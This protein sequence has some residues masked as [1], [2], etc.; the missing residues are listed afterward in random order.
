MQLSADPVRFFYNA[1]KTIYYVFYFNQSKKMH[2]S[3]FRDY[4]L[5]QVWVCAVISFVCLRVDP[6]L[7]LGQAPSPTYD[8]E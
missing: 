7:S 5:T 3:L 1:V 4:K 6:H 8:A 2:V